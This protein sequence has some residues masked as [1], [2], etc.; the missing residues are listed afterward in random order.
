ME[1]HSISL[2]YVGKD[3]LH[4]SLIFNN[5]DLFFLHRFLLNLMWK[6]AMFILGKN[7]PRLSLGGI[8]IIVNIF[9]HF[10]AFCR[11]LSHYVAFSC[12]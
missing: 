9:N 3:K 6:M 12:L 11:I 8:A 1:Y 2:F 4:I 10:V 7:N 5:K